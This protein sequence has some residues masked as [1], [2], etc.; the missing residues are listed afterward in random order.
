MSASSNDAEQSA[1]EEYLRSGKVPMSYALR[2]GV[3]SMVRDPLLFIAAGMPGPLGYKGRQ[4]LY[5]RFFKR[6]GKGVVVDP[7]VRLIGCNRLEVGDFSFLG[8]GCEMHIPEG[9]VSIGKRCHVTGWVLG[10][11]GVEIEDYVACGGTLLSVTDSSRGG[12][13][14]GGPMIPREQRHLRRGKVVVEKD[15]FIARNSTV[16]PG[17]T[18]GEGAVVGPFSLVMQDVKPWTVVAGVPA[19][20]TSVREKVKFPDPD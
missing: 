15:A 10:H 1:K 16:M 12:Y 4:I 13:R 9:F 7:N 20:K 2:Q 8:W 5:R 19:V 14:M 17:V 11:E 3:V 18:I 6:M